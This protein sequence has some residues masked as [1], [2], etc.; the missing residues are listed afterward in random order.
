[1]C[2]SG[3]GR[4]EANE[5]IIRCKPASCWHLRSLVHWLLSFIKTMNETS[6]QSLPLH[7]LLSIM[8][9]IHKTLTFTTPMYRR[10]QHISLSTQSSVA[11]N[12]NKN[13]SSKTA[14]TQNVSMFV[15][16]TYNETQT[17]VKWWMKNKGNEKKDIMKF[18]TCNKGAREMERIYRNFCEWKRMNFVCEWNEM[19]QT[20]KGDEV[21]W[22]CLCV[23]GIKMN[24]WSAFYAEL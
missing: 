7:A 10:T 9:F 8:L 5:A 20:A 6:A 13:A 12:E 15:N 22:C 3:R 1:M 2:R 11:K 14:K 24:E 18:T 21:C 16:E 23:N 4:K 19:E 17:D